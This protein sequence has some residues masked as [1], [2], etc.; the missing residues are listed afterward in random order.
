MTHS[1]AFVTDTHLDDAFTR[2]H[3]VPAREDLI[4][5]LQEIAGKGIR[6]VVI[7]GDIGEPSSHSFLFDALKQHTPDYKVILGNFDKLEDVRQHYHPPGLVDGTMC[8]SEDRD[9]FRYIFLDSS[10]EVLYDAQLQWL[11]Q[12][13]K[14]AG[15]VLLFVHHPV[16]EIPVLVDGL[17]PLQGREKI[18][19]LLLK[20]P[21][22]VYVFCGHLHITDQRQ[23]QNIHQT[24]T[25]ATS[26]QFIKEAAGLEIDL[27]YFGYSIITL[28]GDTVTTEIVRWER[29]R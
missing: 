4:L 15:K 21:H 3:Q 14:T 24:V 26:A 29:D 22:A 5:L 13:L 7:G 12:E 27:S 1:F 2:S 9:G 18:K 20:H 10:S 17:Q 28:T 19:A 16:V 25:P 23:E 11:E 6:E 8:Y